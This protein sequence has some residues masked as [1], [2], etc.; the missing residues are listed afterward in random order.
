MKRALAAAQLE[1]VAAIGKKLARQRRARRGGGAGLAAGERSDR[2]CAPATCSP[3][4][5][6]RR[7]A[8]WPASRSRA[9][10]CRRRSACSTWSGRA[11]PKISSPSAS[12]SAFCSHSIPAADPR[13]SQLSPPACRQVAR[14][15]SLATSARKQLAQLVGGRLAARA[16]AARR[17][18]APAV[19]VP[20]VDAGQEVGWS[21]APD[22]P[23]RLVAAALLVEIDRP[24]ACLR[25][26]ATRRRRRSS[27]SRPRS[28]SA[29]GHACARSGPAR[30]A[31]RANRGSDR[32]PC[33]RRRRRPARNRR[34]ARCDRPG[35][36]WRRRQ[37]GPSCPSR[38]AGRRSGDG[39]AR[40]AAR[41]AS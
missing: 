16:V 39:R 33:V 32:R 10:R 24:P 17:G 30:R 27:D 31:S 6:R 19:P 35:R 1:Q 26:T 25:P 13:P 8:S 28:A 2:R 18:A 40:S 37:S 38:A 5:S 34:T 29:V 11:S 3:A 7:R 41:Q 22:A 23:E 9:P 14:Q 12:T 4:T 20:E 36:T 21:V 15:R